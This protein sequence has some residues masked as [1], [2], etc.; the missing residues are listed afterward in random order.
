M[1]DFDITSSNSQIQAKEKAIEFDSA[2]VSEQLREQ[3]YQFLLPLLTLLD[4]FLDVR[5]VRTFWQAIETILLFR[6]RAHGL[7]LSELGGYLLSPEHAPAGTKRLSNLLRSNKWKSALIAVFLWQQAQERH[8]AL[9]KEGEI[10]LLLWDESVHEKPE[11]K[12]SEGLCAVRSSKAQRLARSRPGFPKPPVFVHGLHWL[13]LLMIG[14]KGK[15]TVAFFRW[16]TNKKDLQA[17]QASDLPAARYDLLKQ[18]VSSW[19]QSVLHV[20]DRGYAGTKW[21][22]ACEELKARFLLRFPKRYQLLD[23]SGERKSAWKIFQGKPSWEE[24]IA[25]DSVTNKP[26][27]LGI[28]ASIVAHP[29]SPDRALWLVCARPGDGKE[30][31]LLL[32]SEPI[33]NAED[34]WQ[35]IQ[36]YARRWQIE[37]SFRFGKSELAMESPRLWTL[38]RREKILMIVSLVYAFLLWLLDPEF[39]ALRLWVL[40]KY[41]HRTGKRYREARAPLYR[42][43]M[44]I[45]RLWLEFPESRSLYVNQNS[46]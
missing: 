37:M 18:C 14:R 7:L 35:M 19:Q 12:K 41:C 21:M 44:A 25:W 38:E 28:L 45:S 29:S 40:D 23:V 9:E 11:S 20:F 31:W 43:R 34:A 4:R 42:L 27:R 6:N 24:R 17:E 30:P 22:E 36:A 8:K 3:L 2:Q 26:R 5:L 46:G 16:F 33:R 13:G 15:P 10:P 32:T 39:L 1:I